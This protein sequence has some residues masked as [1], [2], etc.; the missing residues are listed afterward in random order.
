MKK[1]HGNKSRFFFYALY[2]RKIGN[3]LYE[4]GNKKTSG[5]IARIKEGNKIT[6]FKMMEN[7]IASM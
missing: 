7:E 1:K 3:F 2:A 4:N 5:S 6:I